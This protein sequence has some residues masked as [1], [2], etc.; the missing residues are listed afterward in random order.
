MSKRETGTP[1]VLPRYGVDLN[2]APDDPYDEASDAVE[3]A[4]TLG[5]DVEITEGPD[6]TGATIRRAGTP[7]VVAHH[8]VREKGLDAQA[9]V[10]CVAVRDAVDRTPPG[11]AQSKSTE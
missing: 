5:Y 11:P 6:W 1:S 4:T 9:F 7:F 10:I 2:D 8:A 3:L